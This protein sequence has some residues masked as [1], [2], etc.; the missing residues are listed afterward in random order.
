[1]YIG[2]MKKLPALP[3][4]K[5]TASLSLVDLTEH[6]AKYVAAGLSGAPQHGQGLRRRPEALRRV[7]LAARAQAPASVGRYARRIRDSSGGVR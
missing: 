6:T 4:V 1:M 5:T 7:V 2:R 3:T